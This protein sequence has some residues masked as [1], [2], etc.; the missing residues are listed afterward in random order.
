M[1]LIYSKVEPGRLLHIIHK[2]SD[3]YNMDDEFRRDIVGEDEFIQLSAMN[4]NKGHTSVEMA[5]INTGIHRRKV[6]N[7]LFKIKNTP[8]N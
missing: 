3:F 7:P 5:N 6:T 1:D 8:I 4:M 2:E